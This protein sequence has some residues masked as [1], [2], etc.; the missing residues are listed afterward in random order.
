[1]AAA[2][3][4]AYHA[5]AQER[6]TFNVSLFGNVDTL[7]GAQINVISGVTNKEMR[8]VSIAGLLASSKG[9]SYG[10]Q[11]S[12]GLNSVDG[13]MRGLHIAHYANGV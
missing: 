1:M 5:T 4:L 10:V 8:G 13:N 12:G 11:I 7:R 9:K 6:S 2:A 3:L